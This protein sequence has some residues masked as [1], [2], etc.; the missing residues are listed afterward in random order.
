MQRIPAEQ[1]F[2]KTDR[3][4]YEEEDESQN[5]SG[6]HERESFR[7]CH[8]CFVWQ[9]Q[10]PWK[11][12]G[13]NDKHHANGQSNMRQARKLSAIEP[14]GTQQNQNAADH[15]T[16]FSFDPKRFLSNH[17]L[18]HYKVHTAQEYRVFYIANFTEA[19]YVLH[20]FTKRTQ[21]T[22]IGIFNWRDD[23]TLNCYEPEAEPRGSDC[24]AT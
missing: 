20:A 1:A 12:H 22:F 9:N 11:Q 21:K 5:D 10:S 19:I 14:P 13:Q 8:P 7:Q 17:L 23:G 4:N 18:V 16:E 3:R 2:D 24:H 15:E 6:R